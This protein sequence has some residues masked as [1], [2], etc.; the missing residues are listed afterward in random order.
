[1]PP[2]TSALAAERAAAE[3][4][5]ERDLLLT[6]AWIVLG[7]ALDRE[8]A[9]LL[10]DEIGLE[11]DPLGALREMKER[12][13]AAAPSWDLARVKTLVLERARARTPFSAN[14]FYKTLPPEA[15]P[16]I[17]PALQSLRHAHFVTAGTEIAVNPARKSSRVTIY[18]LKG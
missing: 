10:L 7:H 15:W 17:G 9:L 11:E 5:A 2:P 1:V 8:D 6:A 16:L 13:R 4:D 12:R 3:Q 18:Q 14:C